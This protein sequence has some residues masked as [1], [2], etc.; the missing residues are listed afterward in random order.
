MCSAFLYSPSM[1]KGKRTVNSGTKNPKRGDFVVSMLR[2]ISGIKMYAAIHKENFN[3]VIAA[4]LKIRIYRNY[5][6]VGS[7]NRMSLKNI[8]RYDV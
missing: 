6:E 4:L 3:K 1:G 5:Y 8:S 2:V 7:S